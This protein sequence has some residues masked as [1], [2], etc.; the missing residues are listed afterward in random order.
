M[1]MRQNSKYA[2]WLWGGL[3]AVLIV[4]VFFRFWPIDG[5]LPGLF[6]DESGE[7]LLPGGKHDTL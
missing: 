1:N 6:G 2:Q 7:H 3:L 5:I 4:A